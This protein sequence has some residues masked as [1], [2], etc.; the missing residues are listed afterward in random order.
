MGVA[1]YI[2]QLGSETVIY[3]I[4]GTI[5]R[6]INFF[7]MPLYT[8]V[9]SPSDYG[10]IAIITSTTQLLGMF[11]ILGLD[12]G[13]ARWFYDNDDITQRKRVIASWFW[14]QLLVG[15]I[16][17]L[18]IFLFVPRIAEPLLGSSVYAPV[19][20]IAVW[21][22]PLGTFGRVL[23]NWLRYQRRAWTTMIYFT[24]SSLGTVG[25]I[26]LFV[27]VWR[28]GLTGMY[29]GQVLAAVVTGLAA[30]I[31]F[32]SWIA[33]QHISTKLLKEMLVFGLPFVPAGIASWVTA[34]ADRFIMKMFR[35]T[36][37][38]GIYAVAVTISGGVALLTNAFQ[39]A[40]GPFAFSILNEQGAKQVYSKVLSFYSLLGCW[41]ATTVSLFAPLLL[42][43][44]TTP[45]YYAAASSIPFLVFS[46][47]A[48][49]STYIGV[50]GAGIVKKS[51]PIAA[52]SFLGAG[53]NT[54][55]NFILIPYWGKDGAAISTL[56]AYTMMAVYLFWA[57]QK[58]YPLPFRFSDALVCFGFAWALIG[59]DHLFIPTWGLAAFMLRVGMCLL[60]I[61]LAFWLRIVRPVHIRR[62][63][64]YIGIH[65]KQI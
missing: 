50:L 65:L 41:L 14:C 63:L 37:E 52:S 64:T 46:Y 49:G 62:L 24:V 48:I 47:V 16:T 30:I 28:R 5:S 26:I 23:G 56:V 17:A 3:G 7:L 32:R 20:G 34:S 31:I 33:P 10:V 21:M 55:L 53:I 57:S 8:R 22:I 15:S 4:S 58:L 35:D 13:S 60:F 18:V 39:T 61:P 36:S 29:W 44:F 12:N 59:M 2:K 43:I 42:S 19:L 1:K 27:L 11:I 25:C 54:A 45:Q 38:I 6:F 9:F 51:L 40:W